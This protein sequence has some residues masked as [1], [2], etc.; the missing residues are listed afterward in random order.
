MPNTLKVKNES[1]AL[2]T[3]GEGAAAVDIAAGAD[4]ELGAALLQSRAFVDHLAASEL[5]FVLTPNPDA[6][7]IAL[8]RRVFPGLLRALGP[9]FLAL[10]GRLESSVAQLERRRQ[11]FN[12]FW[13]QAEF[14]LGRADSSANAATNLVGSARHFAVNAAPEQAAEDALQAELDALEATDPAT[15]ADLPAFLEEVRAKEDE[16]AE[17]RAK[18]EAA[19][20][21]FVAPFTGLVDRLDVVAQAFQDADPAADIGQPTPPFP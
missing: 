4:Q 5:R 2:I 19:E 10:D 17:A 14:L 20:A 6:E 18:R 7:R 13:T 11:E 21:R 3:L 12:H 1:A 15:I 9:R 8:A 16:V